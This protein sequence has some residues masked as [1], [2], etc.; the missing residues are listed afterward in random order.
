MAQGDIT[1]FDWAVN[2][3]L[4]ISGSALYGW[5]ITNKIVAK[6]DDANPK[7]SDYEHIMV[8]GFPKFD[9]VQIF[10]STSTG[11]ASLRAQPKLIEPVPDSVNADRV[12]QILLGR[13]SDKL[14]GFMDVTDDGGVTPWNLQ[15][16]PM[17]I[18]FPDSGAI[19]N[20]VFNVEV[21]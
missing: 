18:T 8:L 3:L 20:V 19:T 6:Y 17:R 12:S 10:Y 1:L 15:K 4:T 2:T 7:V 14:F 11:I 21:D 16:I 9:F 13:A 5:P